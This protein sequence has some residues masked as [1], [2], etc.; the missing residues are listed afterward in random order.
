MPH[1]E[2]PSILLI[3][4]DDLG[5]QLLPA[6]GARH[7]LSPHIDALSQIVFERALTV[8]P[9]CTPSRYALLTGTPASTAPNLVAKRFRSQLRPVHFNTYLTNGSATM[10]RHLGRLGFHSC[11]AG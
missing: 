8:S 6:Y 3:L 9:L 11:F 4:V 2:A 5:R 10:A 7:R 1:V